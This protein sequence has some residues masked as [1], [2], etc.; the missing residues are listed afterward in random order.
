MLDFSTEI[1]QVNI[2]AAIRGLRAALGRV[3]GRPKPIPQDEFA[4]MFGKKLAAV[5]RWEAGVNVPPGDVIIKMMRLCPDVECLRAF[6]ITPPV[7]VAAEEKEEKL[8]ESADDISDPDLRRRYKEAEHMLHQLAL[9][10]RAGN[11]A[12][13]EALRTIAATIVRLAGI[14]SEPGAIKGRRLKTL[15]EELRKLSEV[16]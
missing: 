15:D 12:A 3:A 13:A 11:R 9:Q 6:G 5:Q 2:P 1:S 7:A 10:K 8:I 16:L 4:A 14:A